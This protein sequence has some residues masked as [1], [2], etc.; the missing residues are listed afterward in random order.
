MG[1]IIKAGFK[2]F[3]EFSIW[4][5]YVIVH[6]IKVE[7]KE[8]IPKDGALVFCANHRSYLD[9]PLIRVTAKRETF[10]LRKTS[11]LARIQMLLILVRWRYLSFMGGYLR[12]K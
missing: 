2:K 1:K 6:R 3:V 12:R 8:N 5:Y 10:F 7:G 9:A 4:I 11:D